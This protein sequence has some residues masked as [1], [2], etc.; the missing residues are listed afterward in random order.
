MPVDANL[1]IKLLW[2][3]EVSLS[4]LAF[5]TFRLLCTVKEI[6]ICSMIWDY[7]V[8]MYCSTI[9]F[10]TLFK[11]FVFVASEVAHSVKTIVIDAMTC[12]PSPTMKSCRVWLTAQWLTAGLPKEGWL[13]LSAGW[14][15]LLCQ[16][17][18]YTSCTWSAVLWH[19]SQAVHLVDFTVKISSGW[20]HIPQRIRLLVCAERVV[21][22]IESGITN[23][24]KIRN[25]P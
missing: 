21:A 23:Y 16:L 20:L 19:N 17:G 6:L 12:S 8:W 24:E 13:G 18:A 3:Y 14:P 4:H 2:I 5:A 11:G 9:P 22:A 1:Q 7:L 15:W 25:G 10:K